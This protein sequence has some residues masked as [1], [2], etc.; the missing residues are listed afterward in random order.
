M[1]DLATKHS[2]G[3]FISPRC[4]DNG[5][6]LVPTVVPSIH[7]TVSTVNTDDLTIGKYGVK[8]M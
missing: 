7:K 1:A 5:G 2:V 6:T 3:E 8:P 4:E